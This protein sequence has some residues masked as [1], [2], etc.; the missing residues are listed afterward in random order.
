MRK[1]V[2]RMALIVEADDK[3]KAYK[4]ALELV[5]DS[6][7]IAVHGVERLPEHSLEMREDGK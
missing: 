7:N 4:K 6:N 1:Y 2:V 5:K 3:D